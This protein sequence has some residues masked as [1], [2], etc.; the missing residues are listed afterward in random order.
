MAPKGKNNKK[1][2]KRLVY[3]SIALIVALGMV[4]SA[5]VVFFDF[6]AWNGGMPASGVVAVVN[7]EEIDREEFD[8]H[9]QSMKS[10]Y[11]MQGID[12]E[13]QGLRRQIQEQILSEMIG[14]VILLQQAEKEGLTVS[15][16][17]I[18]TRYQEI[19]AQYESE[20]EMEKELSS[21][22]MTLEDL[23]S[24]LA[25]E[26]L[27]DK[28]ISYY[29]EEKIDE[30]DLVVSQEELEERYEQHK[31]YQEEIPEFEEYED[32]L[33]EE[34]KN[35]KFEQNLSNHIKNLQAESNIEIYL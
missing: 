6:L 27:I 23:K 13:E 11:E 35:E 16:E 34:L 28:Y 33:K 2:K 17:D 32:Q 24:N 1:S 21:F 26:I 9:Y 29:R 31:L 14:R 3:A 22:N 25:E 12:V 8:M 18:Q 15:E 30:E 19:L 7:D 5:T 4:F 20:E 10:M